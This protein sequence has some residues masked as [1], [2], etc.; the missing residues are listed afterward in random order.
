[1]LVTLAA[2]RGSAPQELG[3]T[4]VLDA[5]GRLAGTVGGGKVEAWALRTGA[6]LLALP[7]GELRVHRV[8]LQR[9]LGM[10]CGG[11]VTLRFE[12][13]APGGWVADAAAALENG[14]VVLLPAVEDAPGVALD[15]G[16]GWSIA[17]FGAG[18][19]SQALTR[20][21]LTVDCRLTVH[22]PRD[23]WRARLPSDALL[24]PTALGPEA[25][26]GLDDDTY[27][28]VMTQGH[29]TDLPVLERALARPF[30]YV[31]VLGSDTKAGRLRRE[32]LASGA[33]PERVAAL[34]C[35][36]GLP[37]GR[38]TPPEIAISIAGQL[39]LERRPR[40]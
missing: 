7:E 37:V 5:S 24:T 17:I 38:S 3:A 13:V 16:G 27:I 8:N 9:D 23:E 1:M 29:A 19:V 22:E 30:P 34:R 10:T 39:L 14:S 25:V 18:H 20:L 31:G 32:L 40:R 12:K 26:A 11:E 4:L 15:P 36:I 28:V 2:R 35:P 21:L 6:A 33:S